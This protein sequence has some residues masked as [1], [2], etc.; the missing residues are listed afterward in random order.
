MVPEAWICIGLSPEECDLQGDLE[1]NPHSVSQSPLHGQN[2][3]RAWADYGGG[4]SW[5]LERRDED[6]LILFMI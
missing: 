5:S 2:W 6:G 4:A 1:T 3:D